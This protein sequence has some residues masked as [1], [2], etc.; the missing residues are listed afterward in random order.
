MN[1]LIEYLGSLNFGVICGFAI[2][3]LLIA[4]SLTMLAAPEAYKGLQG[5]DIKFF[6]FSAGLVHYWFYLLVVAFG[7]FVLN[8]FLCTLR[9]FKKKRQKFGWKVTVY[10]S[11]LAHIAIILALVSHLVSGLTVREG[12]PRYITETDAVTSATQ[13]PPEIKMRIVKVD[14]AYYENGQPRRAD[15]LVE[16]EENGKITTETLG[17]NRPITRNFGSTEYLMMQYGRMPSA[18]IMTVNGI[19]SSVARGAEVPVPGTS[20]V[21]QVEDLYMPGEAPGLEVPALLVNFVDAGGTRRGGLLRLGSGTVSPAEGLSM[22]FEELQ[23]APMALVRERHNEGI[24][25]LLGSIIL[26]LAG[27]GIVVARVFE[28]G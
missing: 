12:M 22:S 16:V 24:P 5:E 8:L 19:K 10:G 3:G 14:D 17:Y 2:T 21:I 28:R 20:F 13:A 7:L 1:K 11:T 27:M 18:A 4:G 25:I 9:A 26:F 23:K 15:L 6:L